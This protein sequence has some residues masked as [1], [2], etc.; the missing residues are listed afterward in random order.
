MA[1]FSDVET[2]LCFKH[3]FNRLKQSSDEMDKKII[4]Q[5]KESLRT[6]RKCLK[7]ESGSNAS[8]F[9]QDFK[10]DCDYVESQ[11]TNLQSSVSALRD[12]CIECY[13]LFNPSEHYTSE[14]VMLSFNPDDIPDEEYYQDKVLIERYYTSEEVMRDYS[15]ED[16]PDEEYEEYENFDDAEDEKKRQI[17]MMKETYYEEFVSC[18][19]EEPQ[20]PEPVKS[21]RWTK[22][23]LL[24]LLDYANQKDIKGGCL[25]HFDY[26]AD[27]FKGRSKSSCKYQLGKITSMFPEL[28][29]RNYPRFRYGQTF[30]PDKIEDY[31]NFKADLDSGVVEQK[32][33]QYLNPKNK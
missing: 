20:E 5:V 24:H 10:A 21:S 3:L 12:R 31:K 26:L 32:I 15:P 19:D 6:I 33:N 17:N 27:E 30:F 18:F 13:L 9:K 7:Y 2:Y 28:D 23:Q 22:E 11:V 1:H 29:L 4:P 16:N 14:E 8:E 25:H